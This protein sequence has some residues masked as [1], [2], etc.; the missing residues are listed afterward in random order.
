M[1]VPTI[2]DSEKVIGAY[3]RD[4]PYLTALDAR[5][6]PRTP[7]SQVKPWVRVTQLDATDVGGVERLIDYLIQFDCY[8]GKAAM[9]EF[10]GQAEASL[11]ARSVRAALKDARGQILDEEAV[12][13]SVRFEGMPRI[14]DADFEPARERYVLTAAIHMHSA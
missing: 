14:P 8:A 9:D 13:T 10:G 4:H 2:I 12:V 7:S 3:L 5:V 6:A 11:L 1:T